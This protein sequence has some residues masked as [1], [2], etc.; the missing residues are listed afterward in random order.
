MMICIHM[1]KTM[2]FLLQ[3][4]RYNTALQAYAKKAVKKQ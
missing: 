2:H 4:I 3:M 1:H